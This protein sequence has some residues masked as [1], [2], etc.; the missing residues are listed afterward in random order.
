MGKL[1]DVLQKFAN[2]QGILYEQPGGELGGAVDAALA[3]QPAPDAAVPPPPGQAAEQPVPDEEDTKTLT[4][5]GYVEAV[6][7]MLEL[8]EISTEELEEADLD[9]FR[10]K[11][12]PKNAFDIHEKLRDLITR[13]GSPTKEA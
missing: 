3:A 1:N 6:R 12:T 4:D 10:D 7:D 8:L 13:Y 9:I 11:V 5:Q 2:K